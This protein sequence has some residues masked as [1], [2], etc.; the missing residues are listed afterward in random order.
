VSVTPVSSHLMPFSVC[1]GRRH[2]CSVHTNK[3]AKTNILKIKNK[4]RITEK[5]AASYSDAH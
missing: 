1:V 2:T 5:E 4:H 3:Q